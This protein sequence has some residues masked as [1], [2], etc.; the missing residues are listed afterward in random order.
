MNEVC[1]ILQEAR[2][3]ITPMKRW[4]QGTYARD[5]NGYSV[6]PNDPDAVCWCGWGAISKVS[7]DKQPPSVAQAQ[8]ILDQAGLSVDVNDGALGSSRLPEANHSVVLTCYDNAIK[9][10]CDG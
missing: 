10:A 3:L 5:S 8:R 9:Q 6:T 7:A 2:E 4:T 1:E